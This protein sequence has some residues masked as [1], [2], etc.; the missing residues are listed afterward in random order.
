MGSPDPDRPGHVSGGDPLP[1][2]REPGDGGLISVFGVHLHIQRSVHVA[3]DDRSAVAVKECV[4]FGVAGYEDA[5]AA[6][7]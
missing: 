1:V 3:Y 4:G 7:G 5:S 6:L 2:G